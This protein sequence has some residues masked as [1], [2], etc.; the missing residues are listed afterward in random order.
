MSPVFV[1]DCLGRTL[2]IDEEVT[3]AQEITVYADDVGK[4]YRAVEVEAL[5]Q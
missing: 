3:D 2:V 4:F 5:M 1:K